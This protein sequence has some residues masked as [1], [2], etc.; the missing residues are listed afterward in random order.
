M[1]LLL[2]EFGEPVHDRSRL[3]QLALLDQGRDQMWRD[4][5]RARLVQVLVPRVLPQRP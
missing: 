4:R 5:H 2:R 3:V 1:L